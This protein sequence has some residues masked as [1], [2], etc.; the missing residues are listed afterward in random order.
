MKIIFSFFFFFDFFPKEEFFYNFIFVFI[1]LFYFFLYILKEVFF[2]IIR[3]ILKSFFSIVLI[4]SFNKNKRLP[5]IF[6]SDVPLFTDYR[7]NF[8]QN[9]NLL[10]MTYF[11]DIDATIEENREIKNYEKALVFFED[12][13]FGTYDFV[14]PSLRPTLL[15]PLTEEDFIRLRNIYWDEFVDFPKRDH[16][17]YVEDELK[18]YENQSKEFKQLF[19]DQLKSLLV[20]YLWKYPM[21]HRWKEILYKENNYLTEVGFRKLLVRLWRYHYTKSFFYLIKGKKFHKYQRVPVLNSVKGLQ[22]SRFDPIV[23]SF[24]YFFDDIASLEW[25]RMEANMGYVFFGRIFFFF[26]FCFFLFLIYFYFFG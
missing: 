12:Q 2:T 23:N 15:P 11:S 9:I 7:W 21:K 6:F 5:T 14:D 17:L 4:S 19:K 22:N 26:Y 24:A 3:K 10:M 20:V 16:E 13:H 25:D 8:R 1:L 18:F